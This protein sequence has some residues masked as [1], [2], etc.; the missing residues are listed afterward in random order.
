MGDNLADPQRGAR[1]GICSVGRHSK[2]P[3]DAH[4]FQWGL[5]FLIRM[6]DICAD[7]RHSEDRTRCKVM[8]FQISE[9]KS[10]VF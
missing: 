9:R 7:N 6:H 3:S 2:S 1:F 4:P 8:G 5:T 10:G